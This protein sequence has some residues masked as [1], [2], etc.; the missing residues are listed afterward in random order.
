MFTFKT[1]LFTCFILIDS[2]L[3]ANSTKSDLEVVLRR[4]SAEPAVVSQQ[5]ASVCTLSSP[6]IAVC[7]F[8]LC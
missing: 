6:E 5:M 2:N 7:L 3:A 1:V 8:L 4:E